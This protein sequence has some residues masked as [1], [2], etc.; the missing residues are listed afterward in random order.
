MGVVAI[1][2]VGVLLVASDLGR[3]ATEVLV[4]TG[5]G[6][7][8]GT[9][10]DSISAPAAGGDTAIF[11]GGTS[12]G[13]RKLRSLRDAS[14]PQRRRPRGVRR[15][16]EPPSGALEE[17]RCR[18]RLHRRRGWTARGR[19]RPPADEP[20]ERAPLPAR[21]RGDQPCGRG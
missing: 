2:I 17:R 1:A 15:R 6:A 16:R 19:P 11:L 12:A 8:D 14:G 13:R 5:D 3:A 7:A 18:R 10:L 20:R 9:R 4:M 21:R